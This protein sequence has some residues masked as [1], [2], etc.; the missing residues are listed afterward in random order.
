M[1]KTDYNKFLSKINDMTP[2]QRE[3]AIK[4]LNK[5]SGKEEPVM[6]KNDLSQGEVIL[7]KILE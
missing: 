2:W 7:K 3:R 5:I 4:A 6:V 1:K